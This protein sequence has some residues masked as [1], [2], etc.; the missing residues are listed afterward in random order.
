MDFFTAV[1]SRRSV[2][3][4]RA[5]AV[6][7]AKLQKI[8]E[9]AN[10]APSAGNL[11]AYEIVLIK[12][13]KQKEA[14]AE[15]SNNQKFIA[16]APIILV[17]CANPMRSSRYNSRG[18]NLYCIQDATIAASYAQLAATAL[19]LSSVWVGAFD[20]STVSKIINARAVLPIAIIPIGYPN[21]EPE[22]TPRRK[23]SD[24]VHN[25]KLP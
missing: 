25:E 2:R 6:E 12:D 5:E 18:T 23:I 4:F 21:E 14:L 11:Q 10:S 7:Q 13:K 3:A 20:E 15:A 16:E 22:K 9:S 1:S 8:L 24:I 17:F 19:G